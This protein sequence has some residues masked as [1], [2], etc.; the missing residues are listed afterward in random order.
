VFNYWSKVVY[1]TIGKCDFYTVSFFF[2][3][4]SHVHN[5]SIQSHVHNISI[6]SHVHN[7]SIQSHVHNI[8]ILLL[9]M[10][11]INKNV[12]ETQWILCSVL[13]NN[14]NKQIILVYYC[15]NMVWS[16]RNYNFFLMWIWF[17]INFEFLDESSLFPVHCS[18]HWFTEEIIC[19]VWW[20][21]VEYKQ[22]EHWFHKPWSMWT[23]CYIQ[24]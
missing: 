15:S 14:Q 21:L 2:Y 3:I 16:N 11:S 24:V 10:C 19:V 23:H 22:T 8:S 12:S 4:Q 9:I 5:I 20:L 6:Q 13:S 18:Y 7:I 1:L 17:V